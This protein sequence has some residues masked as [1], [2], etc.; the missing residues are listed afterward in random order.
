ML[1][2]IECDKFMS[3][4]QLRPAI[5]F[6]SGLNTILGGKSADN[7]IGKSTFMLII[8]YAFGGDTYK[9]SDASHH[10]G[11]HLIK[12]AFEFNDG[13]HYFSRDI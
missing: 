10:L 1:Y 8:D 3:H 4:G 2:E 13:K 5:R 6:H 12:F 9:A 11:N 7:S